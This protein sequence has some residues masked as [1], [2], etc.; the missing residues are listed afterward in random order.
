M[1]GLS[2]DE[3][4]EELSQASAFIA[5]LFHRAAMVKACE[6]IPACRELHAA[7]RMLDDMRDKHLSQ[8]WSCTLLCWM[9]LLGRVQHGPHREETMVIQ[10]DCGL[11]S[12]CPTI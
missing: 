6:R 8:Y 11:T 12:A 2:R 9:R 1:I 3:G 7:W 10:E 5:A 4:G